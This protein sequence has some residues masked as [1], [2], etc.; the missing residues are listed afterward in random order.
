[1]VYETVL[2][3]DNFNR[4]TLGKQIVRSA[5]SIGFNISEGYGRYPLRRI[6]IFVTTAGGRPGKPLSAVEKA[7][8]RNLIAPER[9]G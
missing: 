9:Y 3:W 8:I 6:R 5:D 2:G 7:R 4:D 1:M